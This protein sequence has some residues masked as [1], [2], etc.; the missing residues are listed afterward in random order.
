MVNYITYISVGI[1][2]GILGGMLGIGGGVILMPFLRFL[3]GLTPT[4]AAGTV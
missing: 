4:T 3:V 1:I 2:A